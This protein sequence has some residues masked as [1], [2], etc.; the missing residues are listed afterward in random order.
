MDSLDGLTL[1]FDL[2]EEFNVAI[3]N[4]EAAQIKNVRQAVESL[5]KLMAGGA[6]EGGAAGE[7]ATA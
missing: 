6:T 3:P 5:K 2:E 1:I 7:P 4:E